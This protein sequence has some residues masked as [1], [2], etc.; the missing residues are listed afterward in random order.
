MLT[1]HLPGVLMRL[2]QEQD[3][4]ELWVTA[5]DLHRAAIDREETLLRH[6]TIEADAQ[7]ELLMVFPEI[8]ILHIMMKKLE[9]VVMMMIIVHGVRRKKVME[10]L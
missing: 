9:V 5:D 3:S 1:G 2:G 4:Q 7:A 10:H 6:N 8:I